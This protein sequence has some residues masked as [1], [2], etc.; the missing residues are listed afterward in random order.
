MTLALVGYWLLILASGAALV[1]LVPLDWWLAERLAA[2]LLVG[3]VASTLLSLGL[4][5]WWGQGEAATL[6]APAVLLL[7]GAG[8]GACR[9][10]ARPSDK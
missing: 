5:L 10:Q 1:D 3:V 4:S 7:L 9:H 2:S 6:T 8:G